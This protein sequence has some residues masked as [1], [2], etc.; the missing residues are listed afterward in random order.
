MG[1]LVPPKAVL[2]GSILGEVHA[3]DFAQSISAAYLAAGGTVILS[4]KNVEAAT[5]SYL[6][7]FFS[8]LLGEEDLKTSEETIFPLVSDLCE[9]LREDLRS[10]LSD[11]GWVLCE[12]S[13]KGKCEY[14]QL[15][16]SPESSTETTYFLLKSR[17][18]AS[19]NML[20]ELC[21]DKSITQTA[22]NNRLTNLLKLR[23][24]TRT[25]RGRVWMYKTTLHQ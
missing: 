4:F 6:K 5:A 25:K 20:Y 23:L 19:A 1:N 21:D 18:E 15:L 24:A 10:F 11:Q 16:G 7:R 22:W 14:V 3:Q 12:V 8:P 13:L 9:D 2:R 17:G